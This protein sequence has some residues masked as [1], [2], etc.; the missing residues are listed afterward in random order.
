MKYMGS[1][2]RIAK[3][4]LPIIL[5]NKRESQWYVEPFVGGCNSIDKVKGKRIGN[6]VHSY[7]IA[8]YTALQRGWLPPTNISEDYYRDIKNYKESNDPA[9]VGYVGFQL[10]YGGKWFG[11]YRRDSIGTRNYSIEAYNHVLRQLPSIKDIVFTNCSYD[12]L[13]LP[14]NS[15]VYCDPPY[16]ATTKYATDFDHIRFWEWVR[17]LGRSGHDVYVSEY[18][19]PQDFECLWQGSIKS[20]LTKDTGSKEGTE[21]LF[22]WNGNL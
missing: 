10:S 6:D 18:T 15:V 16:V 9:I 13:N 19:A 1:K 20:S 7:L 12:Q 11:G 2:A 5:R 14:E 22:K 4:I 21:K 3:Y 17:D 8:F